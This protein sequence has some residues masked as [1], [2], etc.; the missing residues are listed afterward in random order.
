LITIESSIQAIKKGD[1]GNEKDSKISEFNSEISKNA[2]ILDSMQNKNEMIIKEIEMKNIENNNNSNNEVNLLVSA[3]KNNANS[4][5]NQ[6]KEKDPI[7][8]KKNIVQYKSLMKGNSSY[9]NKMF[10]L[11]EDITKDLPQKNKKT[12]Q[13][14]FER[15]DLDFIKDKKNKKNFN[16]NDR[17]YKQVNI[18]YRCNIVKEIILIKNL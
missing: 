4:N 14:L 6:D 1:N 18:F 7:L 17:Y 13:E 5:E 2:L 10:F 11:N 9:K 12:V 15:L 16:F 3:P 8:N